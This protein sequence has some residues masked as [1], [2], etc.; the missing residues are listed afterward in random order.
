MT[1]LF[2]A[3]GNPG[4]LAEFRALLVPAV[5]GLEL[6]GAE[7]ASGWSEPVED[8]DSF[9]A[10]ALIKARAGMRASGLA[11]LA[12]DSGICV[13][14]LNG[15][16]GVFSARWSGGHG[17]AVANRRLLLDR[18]RDVPAA[19]RGAHFTAVLAL[20]TPDG[21]EHT[22]EGVWPGRIA[23]EERG[24]GGFGYDPVF[25]PA[26]GRGYSAAELDPAL[27]DAISHRGLAV[28]AALPS[29]RA[30]VAADQV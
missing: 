27:K 6:V 12:D 19:R 5:P 7:A 20:V 17:D 10:N 4:K 30:L 23:V 11:T 13:D 21:R 8:G 9:T 22:T 3:T 15:M 24:A 18:V 28:T 25:L 29:L 26:D 2:I 1:R 14:A 16:P